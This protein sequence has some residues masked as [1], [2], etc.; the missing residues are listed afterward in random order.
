MLWSQSRIDPVYAVIRR[1]VLQRTAL[2]RDILGA[3][4]ILALELSLI[5]PFHF[6]A[7][8]LAFRRAHPRRNAQERLVRIDPTRRHVHFAFTRRCVTYVRLV[9]SAPLGALDRIFLILDILR[10]FADRQLRRRS[11]DVVNRL[12]A[13]FAPASAAASRFVDGE[14]RLKAF[15]RLARTA[16]WGEFEGFLAN[17]PTTAPPEIWKVAARELASNWGDDGAAVLRAWLFDWAECRRFAAVAIMKEDPRRWMEVLS[18]RH[19]IE[20]ISTIRRLIEA[21]IVD[22]APLRDGA[23]NSVPLPNGRQELIQATEA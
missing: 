10:F 19:K 20:P 16:S 15:R 14:L 4:D 1:E 23:E 2:V 7:E 9:M 13:F 18:K 22:D 3:D 5:G 11:R 8:P 6:V 12:Q 21:A 17:L